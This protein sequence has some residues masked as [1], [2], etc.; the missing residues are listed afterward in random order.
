MTNNDILF[1]LGACEGRFTVYAGCK[2]LKT[3]SFEPDCYNYYV[4]EENIKLNN[5]E[6]LYLYLKM[7][8]Q[9]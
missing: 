9:I 3:Y 5:L 6:N 4:L 8:F 2:N 7:L 1:D